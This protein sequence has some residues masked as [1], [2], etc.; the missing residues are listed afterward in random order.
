[1]RIGTS[2]DQIRFIEAK[3]TKLTRQGKVQMSAVNIAWGNNQF[4]FTGTVAMDRPQALG[5]KGL[6]PPAALVGSVRYRPSPYIR[7]AR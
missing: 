6:P 5:G 7:V 1:M 4:G 3:V 2:N